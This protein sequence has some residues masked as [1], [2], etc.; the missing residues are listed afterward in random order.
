MGLV[1]KA[2]LEEIFN[3]QLMYVTY[4]CGIQPSAV[5]GFIK[6]QFS[7]TGHMRNT[8]ISY[9]T[10]KVATPQPTTN[11]NEVLLQNSHLMNQILFRMRSHIHLQNS[12]S[13]TKASPSNS[14]P[15]SFKATTRVAVL[16]VPKA[17][18]STFKATFSSTPNYWHISW[19]ES[20][21]F[22]VYGAMHIESMPD[23]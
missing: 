13:I 2:M 7:I 23:V 1:R 14:I 3:A 18:L 12:F 21:S 19:K 22:M 6:I 10:A 17:N 8:L 16:L 11:R 4:H 15:S 20:I 5:H 9:W